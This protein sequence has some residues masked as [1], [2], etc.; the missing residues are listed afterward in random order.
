MM[1]HRSTRNKLRWQATK[2]TESIDKYLM[3]ARMI[4]DLSGGQ[5]PVVN[6]TLLVLTNFALELQKVTERFRESL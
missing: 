3:H 1:T 2:M 4:D 6:A 5:S